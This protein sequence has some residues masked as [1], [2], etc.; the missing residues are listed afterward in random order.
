[1][2]E[3][4]T[5]QTI[6]RRTIGRA[7]TLAIAFA[8]SIGAAACSSDSTGPGGTNSSG[9]V[10]TY[11]ITTVNGKAL[12]VAM[13]DEPRY[14]YEVVSG[15]IALS[16]DGKYVNVTNFRQTI[17]DDISMITDSTF[18]TWSQSGS[19]INLVNG[20]DPSATD[21]GTVAG[22][23]LTFAVSDGRTTTTYVYTKK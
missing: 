23:Q 22:T 18:G 14:K 17:P 7:T 6:T 15:S 21:Q 11:A 9:V 3:S 20:Q 13:F 5:L 19:Q 4:R 1:M 12:P 10:G 2:K 16:S 8:A